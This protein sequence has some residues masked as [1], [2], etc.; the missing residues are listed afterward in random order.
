MGQTRGSVGQTG[1][2]VEVV[3][4]VSVSVPVAQAFF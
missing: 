1:G 2:S 4:P 3:F